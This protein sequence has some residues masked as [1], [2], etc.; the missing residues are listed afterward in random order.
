MSLLPPS[1]WVTGSLAALL[2]ALLALLLGRPCIGYLRAW[3]IGQSIRVEGPKSHQTKAGTPTMG[4]WI[5]LLPALVVFAALQMSLGGRALEGWMACGVTLAYGGLGWLDDYLIIKRHSNKGLSARAKLWGQ[6]LIAALFALLLATLHHGTWLLVPVWH[7]PLS[8]GWAYYG[9]TVLV[10]VAST[11]A[12][13]LTDGLD[14]LAAGTCIPAFLA[15]SILLIM[16]PVAPLAWRPALWLMALVG[17][18]LGFLWYNGHPA[19]VFMGDTGSLALG[20]ALGA[21]AILGHLELY[22]LVIGG[23]FVAEALSVM[24][25]VAYF[26]RTGGKRIFR[27]SPLH[28]HFELGGLSET[29]VVTRFH[30]VGAMLALAALAWL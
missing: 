27:M 5:I 10:L 20:G 11:N 22:L 3:K 6:V 15:L 23:V 2:S 7:R 26:K 9:L 14:A 24:L 18:C 25:Q 4:G 28:H 8:L 17:G 16:G 19:Q 29:K 12:V 13:N 21:C 30:M 1:W